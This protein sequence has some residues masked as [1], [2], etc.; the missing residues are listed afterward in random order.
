LL[1]D[2]DVYFGMMTL[3]LPGYAPARVINGMCACCGGKVESTGGCTKCSHRTWDSRGRLLAC[4]CGFHA[5]A[6]S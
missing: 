1:H 3:P 5:Q 6:S 4:S 2:G